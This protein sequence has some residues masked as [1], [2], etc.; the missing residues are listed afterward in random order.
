[1]TLHVNGQKTQDISLESVGTATYN[2]IRT[3]AKVKAHVIESLY[4]KRI[5]EDYTI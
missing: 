4:L 5:G 3:T 2:N 1:M